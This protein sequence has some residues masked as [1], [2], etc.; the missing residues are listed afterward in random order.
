MKGCLRRDASVL[1]YAVEKAAQQVRRLN[2]ALSPW[3]LIDEDSKH[4]RE[5]RL[6]SFFCLISN[7]EVLI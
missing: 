7:S 2:N 4:R 6:R 1:R 5:E 3:P